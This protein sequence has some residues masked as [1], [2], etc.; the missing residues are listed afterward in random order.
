[1]G[2]RLGGCVCVFLFSKRR[3]LIMSSRERER[4]EM[5]GSVSSSFL[6]VMSILVL[7]WRSVAAESEI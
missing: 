3:F 2:V 1:M 6:I 7:L 4:P 5:V